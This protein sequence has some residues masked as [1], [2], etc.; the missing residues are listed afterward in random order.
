M[1]HLFAK[2]ENKIMEEENYDKLEDLFEK[3]D[4]CTIKFIE[5]FVDKNIKRFKKL[6]NII[7]KEEKFQ[8]SYSFVANDISIKCNIFNCEDMYNFGVDKLQITF[9]IESISDKS[10]LISIKGSE[11]LKGC[12]L[13][14]IKEFQSIIKCIIKNR[15][16][17]IIASDK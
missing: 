15:K 11:N 9:S 8:S 7:L 17:R 16:M 12:N 13:Q 2:K 4:T 10:I 3:F 6:S 14:E 1:K 5:A